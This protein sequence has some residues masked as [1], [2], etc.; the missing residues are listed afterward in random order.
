M[1]VVKRYPNRKL[2]DTEA[3]QYITLDGIADM[4]RQG[5]E[6]Q[7]VDHATGEDLTAL[8]L[9]QIIFEQ[10][11]KQRGFLP[12]NVLTSLVQ[13]GGH[14]LGSLRRSLSSPLDLARDV[15]EEIDRRMQVLVR[16]GELAAEEA[17]RLHDRLLDHGQ[18]PS[19]A[20]WPDDEEI[21]RVLA[22][23]GIP[24]R[25]EFDQLLDQ[26]R[27]LEAKLDQVES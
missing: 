9:S 17:S 26:L 8:T 2:Y 23:R 22:Q 11:K 24:T 19:A 16:R 18:P 14:T 20:E 12:Q 13:A 27:E 1:P 3:R 10:E 21:E 7:V 25:D 6:V 4:I 5:R 15:D